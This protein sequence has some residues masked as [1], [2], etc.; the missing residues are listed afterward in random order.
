M[1]AFERFPRE[2]QLAHHNLRK[3]RCFGEQIS[4][5]TKDYLAKHPAV[6]VEDSLLENLNPFQIGAFG[7]SDT[8]NEQPSTP[9]YHS[10]SESESESSHSDSNPFLQNDFSVT[11]FDCNVISYESINAMAEITDEHQHDEPEDES[12]EEEKEGPHQQ[13]G[14]NG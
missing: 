14:F 3:Y 10:G 5:E 9:L 1:Q 11:P 8:Q 6:L 2:S 13:Y 4:E 12:S 7:S